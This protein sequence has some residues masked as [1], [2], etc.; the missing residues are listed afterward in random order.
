MSRKPGPPARSSAQAR[1]G[2]VIR[3]TGS[4]VRVRTEDGATFE[5]VISGRLRL[6]GIET[7]H[8][9]AVGDR[10][11]VEPPA[12]G[13]PGVIVEVLPRDNYLLRKAIAQGRKAHI[14]AAN[15]DQVVMVFSLELPATSTGFANRLL[16]VAEAYDIPA[17]MVFNKTD[18]LQTPEQQAYLHELKGVYEAAGYP[19]LLVS[20][21]DPDCRAAV[22]KVLEGK[23]SLLG[24]HSGAGKSALVN[25]V[26]P[27]LNL[28]TGEISDYS[29]KG[30][31]TTTYAE[32]HDLSGGGAVIDAP[33]IKEFGL[34]DMA[35]DD[36]GDYFPEIHRLRSAC[37][38]ASC[39]HVNE[40]GCAVLA[41]VEAGTLHASRYD[42]Y[43]RMLEEVLAD[44]AW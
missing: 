37:K 24:G 39:R 7:T 25:L 35:P 18:L 5:S 6:K 19:V 2:L 11:M 30:R 28:R 40:P 36:L 38:Y 15:L 29:L 20:A 21:L 23:I 3:S 14:L 1:R 43:L 32:L 17:V 41:A 16:A 33:G 31:H 9:V 34:I 10:V 22:A 42:T 12:A 27:S 26:D 44:Q 4:Q 8:P 13:K